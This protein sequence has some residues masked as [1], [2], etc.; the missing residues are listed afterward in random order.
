MSGEYVIIKQNEYIRKFKKADATGPA[1]A[2]PLDE[3][4]VRNNHVFRGLHRRG[5]FVEA[6]EGR[7]YIDLDQAE[8]FFALRRK[9]AFFVGMAV[10]IGVIILFF[11]GKLL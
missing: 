6:G 7:F 5:V 9:I 2:R 10:V 11:L 1:S 4:R 8:E 3:L